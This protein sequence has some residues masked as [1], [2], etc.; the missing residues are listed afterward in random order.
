MVAFKGML[1]GEFEALELVIIKVPVIGPV[2]SVTGDM[3]TV[4]TLPF[5]LL[6]AN[7]DDES[8]ESDAV[9]TTEAE[10]QPVLLMLTSLDA[11]CPLVMLPKSTVAGLEPSVA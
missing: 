1:N 5:T 9:N 10:V 8:A 2:A 11:D 6:I 7:A 4:T 3:D